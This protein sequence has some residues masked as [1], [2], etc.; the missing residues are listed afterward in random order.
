MLYFSSYYFTF[1]ILRSYSPFTSRHKGH[2]TMPLFFN[3]YFIHCEKQS[4]WNVFLQTFVHDVTASLFTICIWQIAHKFYI[5]SSSS[6]S[7]IMLY[8]AP[9]FF[10]I[11]FKKSLIRFECI[12]RLAIKYLR[13]LSEYW[14]WNN[15]GLSVWM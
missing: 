2:L 5:S 4:K 7:I 3:S 12:L 1:I 8:L 11:H 15:N 13:S 10:L 14:N 6:Y 9:T